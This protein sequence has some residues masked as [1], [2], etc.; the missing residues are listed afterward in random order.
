MIGFRPADRRGRLRIALRRGLAG[1]LAAATAALATPAGAEEPPGR[2]V[3]LRVATYNIQAGAGMDRQFDLE[4]QIE[5]LRAIDADIISL[6]EVDV[7]W[8]ARSEWRDLATEIAGALGM[9]AFFGHI[10]QS[11]PPAPDQPPRQFG[12]AMLSRYPILSAEN[13]EITRLSTQ[14]PDPEPEPAPGF[15]EILVNV[16]GAHVHVYGTHLDFRADPG[17]REMQVADMLRI[18]ARDRG[19]RQILLGDFNTR[20][21]APELGPLWAYVADAWVVANGAEGGLTFP[22]NTPNRRIDYVAVSPRV[23]V[24]EVSVPQTFASD[25]FPVTAELMVTRGENDET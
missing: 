6:Q 22:A 24:R 8:S 11:D 15:P 23:Q 13:H 25:H 20:P 3:N 9:N 4:R 16:R 2:E 21:D 1:V 10:Y 12:I 5:A 19:R 7:N 17:V 18:M 14:V